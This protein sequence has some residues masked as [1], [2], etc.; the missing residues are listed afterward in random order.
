MQTVEKVS[1]IQL[2]SKVGTNPYAVFS[3]LRVKPRI[4]LTR[5]NTEIQ[6]A[7]LTL[8]RKVCFSWLSFQY[9]NPPPIP[10]PSFLFPSSP[11][12]AQ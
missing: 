8:V 6:F 7:P 12:I 1:I 9:T 4:S 10:P 5:I 11:S 3:K 2:L